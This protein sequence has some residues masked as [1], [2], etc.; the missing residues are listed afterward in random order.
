MADLGTSNM[1]EVDGKEMEGMSSGDRI[2][3]F[4]SRREFQQKFAL[5]FLC[6]INIWIFHCKS[7]PWFV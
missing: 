2:K 7:I 4:T 1:A 6:L 5:V 3:K